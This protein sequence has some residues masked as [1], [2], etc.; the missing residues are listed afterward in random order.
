MNNLG[1]IYIHQWGTQPIRDGQIFVFSP[2][3]APAWYKYIP[4][5]Q[6]IKRRTAI[7]ENGNIK[8]KGDNENW[9]TD[10]RDGMKPVPPNH[11]AGVVLAA[12]SPRRMLRWFSPA[13]RLENSLTLNY[14]PNWTK[15][16][17]SLA[18]AWSPET[19]TTK[20]FADGAEVREFRGW[21][22]KSEW[23]NGNIKLGKLD[24]GLW[25]YMLFAPL[26]NTV[27][28]QI[29]LDGDL[30]LSDKVSAAY[31]GMSVSGKI[32]Y[33]LDADPSTNWVVDSTCPVINPSVI[34]FGKPFTGQLQLEGA[35][36]SG[37][38]LDVV[39]NGKPTGS[40]PPWGAEKVMLTQAKDV[41]LTVRRIDTCETTTWRI[42][43]IK[44]LRQ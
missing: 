35:I 4:H 5:R 9:S 19:N 29:D 22:I 31:D 28:S 18:A 7:D 44:F 25:S 23:K 2:A 14:C 20:V 12:W 27:K 34:T 40:F 1:V 26:T 32:C 10:D 6:W 24:N 36:V 33:A 11:V 30:V 42:T 8:F 17:G 37:A 13:G 43:G 15:S 3:N 16:S 38:V 41:R 39:V 21:S